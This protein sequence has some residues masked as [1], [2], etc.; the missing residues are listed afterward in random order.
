[1]ASLKKLETRNTKSTAEE[2]DDGWRCF[3]SYEW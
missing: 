2:K 1:M 3:F